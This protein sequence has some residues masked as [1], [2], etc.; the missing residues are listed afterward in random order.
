VVRF[1]RGDVG[2]VLQRETDV[3]QASEQTMPGKVVNLEL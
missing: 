2:I 1:V 3:V